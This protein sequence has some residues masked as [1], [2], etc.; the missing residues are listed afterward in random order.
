MKAIFNKVLEKRGISL[1]IVLFLIASFSSDTFFSKSNLSN[2]LLQVSTDGIVAIGMTYVILSG[3]IDLSVGN[4]IA[5]VSVITILV[6]ASH[7]TIAGI[8]LALIAALIIGLINGLLVAKVGVSPFVTTLGIMILVKGI[9]LAIS[10]SKSHSG[11]DPAFAS[12]ADKQFLG[13]PYASIIFLLLVLIFDF[14][15]KKTAFGREFYAVGGN[16]EASWLAGLNVDKYLIFA[17]MF[18]SFIT[19]VGGVIVTSRINTGSPIIAA[20]TSTS[21]I[22]A[23]LLGGT[24]MAGGM[25][26]V[27]NTLWGVLIIGILKNMMNLMGI[28][29]YYQTILLGLLLIISVFWDRTNFHFMQSNK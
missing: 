16:R 2:V 10:D 28:G 11:T 14:V 27:S 23:V 15:L 8:V 12:F 4:L 19:A 9:A 26:S 7:G 5:L 29:G 3:G 20:D 13:L 21:V 1:F 25:G 22:S 24:S 18:C 17:Y 6:Q